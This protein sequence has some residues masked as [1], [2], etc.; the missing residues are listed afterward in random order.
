MRRFIRVDLPPEPIINDKCVRK[1]LKQSL[2][3]SCSKVCPVDAITFSLLNVEIDNERCFQ[4]GNC[5]FTCP[6]DAIENISPHA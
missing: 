4:C 3:D 5:L 2:C 6:V 1:R